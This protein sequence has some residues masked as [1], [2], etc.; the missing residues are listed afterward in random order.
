MKLS[1]PYPPCLSVDGLH[2]F[3][4]SHALQLIHMKSELRRQ[5]AADVVEKNQSTVSLTCLKP[6]EEIMRT[7]FLDICTVETDYRQLEH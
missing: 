3:V 7:E 6:L 2:A 5:F 1:L 4:Q